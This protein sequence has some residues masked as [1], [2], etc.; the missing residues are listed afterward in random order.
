MQQNIH[1]FVSIN[2]RVV[3]ILA[4]GSS[5]GFYFL[6]VGGFS[7]L[8]LR[9]SFRSLLTGFLIVGLFRFGF[10]GFLHFGRY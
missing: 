5:S 6:I 2:R 7:F 3:D 9:R 10:V 4:P 8:I 1:L